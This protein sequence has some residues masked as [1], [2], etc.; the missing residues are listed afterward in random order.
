[1][2]SPKDIHAWM[3]ATRANPEHATQSA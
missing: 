1:L 3:D 2:T